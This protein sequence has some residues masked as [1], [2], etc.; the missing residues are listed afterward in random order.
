M[1]ATLG[2]GAEIDIASGAEL[3]EAKDSILSA[4]GSRKVPVP[5]RMVRSASVT[6]TGSGRNYLEFGSPPVGSTW[7]I[8]SVTTFG[9]NDST[10]VP[11]V[12]GSLYTGGSV[13]NLS[14]ANLIIPGLTFP[15]FVPLDIELYVN[16]QEEIL[17]A[18]DLPGDAGQNFGANIRIE[19]WRIPER[20]RLNG[21]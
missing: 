18:T 19:E 15:V 7:H 14:L 9:N 11:T 5:I 21:S 20:E 10:V 13:D 4:F 12:R 6:S 3:N 2:L 1:K 17:I 16:A 8:I